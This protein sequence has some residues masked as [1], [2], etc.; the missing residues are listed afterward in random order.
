MGLVADISVV[1]FESK[2]IQTGLRIHFECCT[3]K[4]QGAKNL[5]SNDDLVMTLINDQVKE[6]FMGTF[7]PEIQI[8]PHWFSEHEIRIES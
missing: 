8:L 6:E 5:G 3:A 4:S 2:A 1:P 7:A